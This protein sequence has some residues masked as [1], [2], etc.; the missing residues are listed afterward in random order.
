[1]GNC[2]VL[3][4]SHGQWSVERHMNVSLCNTPAGQLIYVTR[5]TTFSGQ[6]TLL[7]EIRE[8]RSLFAVN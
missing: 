6:S 2:I 4:S 5:I 7:T 1:M 8:L 3:E